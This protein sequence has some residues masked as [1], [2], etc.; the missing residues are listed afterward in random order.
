M[1]SYTSIY[2]N[3]DLKASRDWENMFWHD[4]GDD[5]MT[6]KLLGA[7]H[8]CGTDLTYNGYSTQGLNLRSFYT[9]YIFSYR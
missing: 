6:T 8:H 7:K 9:G 2:L 4:L 3:G 5:S 1:D